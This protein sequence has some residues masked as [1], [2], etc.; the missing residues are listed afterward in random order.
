[1]DETSLKTPDATA[2]APLGDA[3]GSLRE[4]A[5]TLARK[6]RLYD[7]HGGMYCW[8]CHKL[9]ATLP[10]L[11]CP[12]C[13]G[14]ALQQRANDEEIARTEHPETKRWRAIFRNMTESEFLNRERAEQLQR[15][16]EKLG[17]ATDERKAELQR[18]FDE[19]FARRQS[20]QKGWN[21]RGFRNQ[22]DQGEEWHP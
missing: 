2:V 9:G 18:R 21:G 8:N 15:N 7:G 6:E 11:H 3:L 12:A 14:V 22:D 13:L 1:M 20:Q 5:A 10:T 19:R 16:A 17:S 4:L